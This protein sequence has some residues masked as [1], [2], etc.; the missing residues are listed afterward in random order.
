MM[1]YVFTIFTYTHV[2]KYTEGGKIS[3]TPFDV[4]DWKRLKI[5]LNESLKSKT[6]Y[7]VLL[8]KLQEPLSRLFR[9]FL[10]NAMLQKCQAAKYAPIYICLLE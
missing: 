1:L 3:I 6:E 8:P 10:S 7:P 9:N 2:L 5:L 4:I